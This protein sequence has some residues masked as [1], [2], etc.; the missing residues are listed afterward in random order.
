MNTLKSITVYN[1]NVWAQ[2][3]LLRLVREMCYSDA[4]SGPGYRLEYRKPQKGI[5]HYLL[6][7]ARKP[8]AVQCV[9]RPAWLDEVQQKLSV[10]LAV[11]GSDRHNTKLR[12]GGARTPLRFDHTHLPSLFL[13]EF[14]HNRDEEDES[15][16]LP[17]MLLSVN[18]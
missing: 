3:Y 7:R 13:F 8:V 4:L 17:D 18:F 1:R 10:Y 5:P 14:Q 6:I 16:A 9:E 15:E 2:R 11:L 12:V